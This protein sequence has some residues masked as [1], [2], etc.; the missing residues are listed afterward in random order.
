MREGSEHDGDRD[1]VRV[2]VNKSSNIQLKKRII[3]L[4][5]IEIGGRKERGRND[6]RLNRSQYNH[7]SNRGWSNKRRKIG[8]GNH[9]TIH[10]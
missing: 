1:P 9:N 10:L 8:G 7:G 3:V 4:G 2:E 6:H 5:I